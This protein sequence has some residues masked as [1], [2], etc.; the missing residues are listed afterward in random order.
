[1]KRFASISHF[2]LYHSHFF[3]AQPIQNHEPKNVSTIEGLPSSIVN[4]SVCVISGE[5]HNS[6]QDAFVDGPEPL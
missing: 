1:M 5:I 3:S 6:V 2:L 4:S